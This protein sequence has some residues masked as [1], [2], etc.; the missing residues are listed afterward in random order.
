MNLLRFSRAKF[1]EF[2]NQPEK[3][4]R[5]VFYKKYNKIPETSLIKGFIQKLKEARKEIKQK[6]NDGKSGLQGVAPILHPEKYKGM[7]FLMIYNF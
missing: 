5:A 7:I 6:L 2:C 3:F 4:N 1:C